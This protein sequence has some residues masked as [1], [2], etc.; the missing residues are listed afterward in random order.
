M[1]KFSAMLILAGALA[2]CRT[3]STGSDQN[4]ESFTF[5]VITDIQYADKAPQGPRHY[6]TSLSRLEECTG[7]LNRYNLAFTIQLG[8]II[9]GNETL[10][11]SLADLKQIL[12]ACNELDMPLYHVVGNHCLEAGKTALALALGMKRFY[13]AFTVPE[14][15]GWHFIVLDGNDAGYGVLGEAQ[16]KWFEAELQQADVRGEQ[17]IVFNHFAAQQRAASNGSM[18]EPQPVLQLIDQH[19]CVEAYFAGHDHA[20][21]YAYENGVHHI[22][23]RGMVEAPETNAYSIIKVSPGTLQVIG[24]GKEPDRQLSL[25]MH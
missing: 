11:Q 17:V 15:P 9:D 24:F 25:R 21:G 6:R 5:G 23:F 10:D 22:T 7:E 3:P 19:K 16:L 20:G 13:Y 2:G 1:T 8:D 12:N 14:A 4:Q 18:R